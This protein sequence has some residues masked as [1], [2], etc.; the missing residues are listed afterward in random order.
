M[1]QPKQEQNTP[2][3]GEALMLLVRRSRMKGV[4]A[5]KALGVQPESLSRMYQ[6]QKLTDRVKMEASRVFDVPLSYFSSIGE[7]VAN[8][9]Q[10]PPTDRAAMLEKENPELEAMRQKLIAEK[11]ITEELSEKL[12]NYSSK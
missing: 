3:E 4:D 8:A 12:K 7:D 10:R 1:Q 5:A 11:L 2:H 9:A 6:R